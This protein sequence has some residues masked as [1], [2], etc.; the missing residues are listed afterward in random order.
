MG[1]YLAYLKNYSETFFNLGMPLAGGPRLSKTEARR[2]QKAE[3]GKKE[4]RRKKE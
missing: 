4:E 3:R 2:K 1:T